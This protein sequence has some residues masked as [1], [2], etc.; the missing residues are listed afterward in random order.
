MKVRFLLGPAGSGKTHACLSEIRRTLIED[1]EGPP[2]V[3]LAPKQATFQLERQLL[4][5][6]EL[7]GYTRLQ[8][9][10]FDRLAR[11]ILDELSIEPNEFLPE[12]GRL[13]ILR[14]LL[15]REKDNLAMYRASANMPGFAAQLSGLLRELQ[16]SRMTPKRVAELA[17]EQSFPER[18]R[19]KLA[20]LAHIAS[21]YHGWLKARHLDDADRALEIAG[22]Q[23]QR[24]EIPSRIDS[25]SSPPVHLAGL[26]LDGFA[27]MTPQEIEL[28]A[29]VLPFCERATL[30]FC[31]PS[32]PDSD[33]SGFSLWNVIGAS[34]RQCRQR[35]DQLPGC[36]VAVEMIERNPLKSR[37]VAPALAVLEAQWESRSKVEHSGDPE[38]IRMVSCFD[39]ESE[40]VFAAREIRRHARQGGR[41]RDVTVLV[42]DL[43]DY[44]HVI[45][46]VFTRYGIP[47]FLDQRESAA[48]HP[49]AEL[50]RFALRT[51][52]WNWQIE[53]WFGLLKTGLC[54]VSDSRIDFL[55]NLAL[56]F[57][58][59]A[60]TWRAG[61]DLS[62]VNGLDEA[63]EELRGRA[64][65][66]MLQLADLTGA[67][68][69]EPVS[70]SVLA[71][72]I[73]QLWSAFKV[74]DQLE[75]WSQ[76]RWP[77]AESRVH[78]H[79]PAVVHR[80]IWEQMNQWL[81]SFELAFA[82]D[83]SAMPLRDWLPIVE[84]GLGN[85]SVGVIPPS[86]DQ[87]LVG[88]IDRTRNPELEIAFVLGMNEGVF[89]APSPPP[90][91]IT[92]PEREQ[93]AGE[94]AMLGTPR[95]HQLAHERYLGYIAC[96]RPRKKLR[97]TW[98][99]TDDR[100]RAMQWSSLIDHVARLTG[101]TK[102]ETFS[103]PVLPAE[104]EHPSEVVA[105]AMADNGEAERV[106]R[107]LPSLTEVSARWETWRHAREV[108]QLSPALTNKLF[109]LPWRTSVSALET[110][111]Q[112]PFRFYARYG[113]R[114]DER[115]HFEPDVREK[116]TY[117][118]DVLEEFHHCAM[119]RGG[120]DRLEVEAAKTLLR[121]VA[122]RVRSSSAEGK[123]DHDDATRFQAETLV[124][125]LEKLIVSMVGW[126]RT[127]AFRPAQAELGFGL[128]ENSPLPALQIDLGEDRSMLLRGRI[129]RIDL[130]PLDDQ[131]GKALVV[132]ADYKSSAKKVDEMLLHNG[133]Q[134]QLLS[135]LHVVQELPGLADLLGQK[136]LIPAGV[137]YVSLRPGGGKPVNRDRVLAPENAWRN[138][139][140]HQGRLNANWF[141]SFDSTRGNSKQ[142]K[143]KG[144]D[145]VAADE[146]DRLREM[147][148]QHVKSIGARV[149]DGEAGVS[150][151]RL[152]GKAPCDYCEYR[153]ICRF[154]HWESDYRALKRPPRERDA[155]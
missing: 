45:R 28:L 57:G 55:E 103:L 21:A 85:L 14:A 154:D 97:L 69:G 70:G 152:Q 89:P 51:I 6:D 106:L 76:Q 104:A 98:T 155:N 146:F 11:Y 123:L 32:I 135:Y 16:R 125:N 109:P 90:L 140:Q 71:L 33:E 138:S 81:E 116:G 130:L 151:Y 20:D 38:A 101:I 126:M 87:V 19:A 35:I 136:Q 137:F 86:I 74:A 99:A 153:S 56:A 7:A 75:R 13:M 124:G 43:H 60:H 44:G 36:E 144:R 27:E 134:L 93:L 47:F 83:E 108:T 147:V 139:F 79:E 48:H 62:K 29:T 37:F 118:H 94:N 64:V 150:P 120:W 77:G 15:A 61:P 41:Y 58:W 5:D 59:D 72:A 25:H 12:E 113:L 9:L 117:Q 82:D 63:W 24:L 121:E 96:T 65:L 8:I 78:F 119:E 141:D 67:A 3:L 143:S 105:H 66:P 145:H 95:L 131:P 52:A 107:N 127:Y 102:P 88:A 22:E 110:F 111:S 42:R 122:E 91:L 50:T 31:L 46:R 133:L 23:L 148:L 115:K 80:T 112:C 2:L 39:R 1:P 17:G 53:D 34:F 49:I 26:W 114:A 128:A 92:D 149:L 84:V 40:A 54:G 73:R 132:I 10:S 100:G 142:F 18:L 129:D 68:Q 4:D 30:A